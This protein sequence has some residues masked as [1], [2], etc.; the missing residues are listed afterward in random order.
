MQKRLQKI[1][2]KE[3]N[4]IFNITQEQNYYD[5]NEDVQHVR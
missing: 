4:Q 1:M 3:Y 2:I 5:F